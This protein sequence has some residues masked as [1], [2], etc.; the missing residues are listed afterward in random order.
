MRMELRFAELYLYSQR[1]EKARF[2]DLD[3]NIIVFEGESA[4]GKSCVLKSLFYVFGAETK[5]FPEWIK[6]NVRILLKFYIGKN[7]FY[8]SLSRCYIDF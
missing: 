4:T 8:I 2:V 1:E 6:K 7:I 5:K 3:S